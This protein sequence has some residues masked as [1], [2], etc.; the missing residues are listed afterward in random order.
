M[1][2]VVIVFRVPRRVF[3]IERC[4]RVRDSSARKQWPTAWLSLSVAVS[5]FI[6]IYFFPN[7]CVILRLLTYLLLVYNGEQSDIYKYYIS[8]CDISSIKHLYISIFIIFILFRC[9]C[10]VSSILSWIFISSHSMNTYRLISSFQANIF[11]CTYKLYIYTYV[12]RRMDPFGRTSAES[13]PDSAQV[14]S[15]HIYVCTYMYIVACP[16]ESERMRSDSGWNQYRR[17]LRSW[18]LEVRAGRGTFDNLYRH[19]CLGACT[20]APSLC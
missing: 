16:C 12:N 5:K 17:G 19:F 18:N 8:A 13:S 11:T 7:A 15:V 3:S 14:H 6:Y 10:N 1:F 2:H 4:M 20:H 9:V